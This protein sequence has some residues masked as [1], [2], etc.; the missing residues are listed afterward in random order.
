VDL[1]KA[2]GL[3]EEHVQVL[4]GD[5]ELSDF[6]TT[7]EKTAIRW[8]ELVTANK[9]KYAEKDFDRLKEHFTDPEI[10]ELTL[11]VGL[12]NMFNRFT[13]ALHI[14]PGESHERDLTKIFLKR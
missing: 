12:F 1:G 4:G 7:R 10:V 5:Y 13:D 11:V 2:V 6:L 9:A 14:E 3:T 8:A